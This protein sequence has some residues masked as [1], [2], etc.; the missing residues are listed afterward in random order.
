[1]DP[2]SVRVARRTLAESILSSASGL[3]TVANA[4]IAEVNFRLGIVSEFVEGK[5]PR[6][7]DL[8]ADQLANLRGINFLSGNVDMHPFNLGLSRVGKL[9]SFDSDRAFWPGL[10]QKETLLDYGFSVPKLYTRRFVD[11][12]TDLEPARLSALL[13]ANCTP[14]EIAGVQFRREL[15]LRDL[16]IRG[17]S[18]IVRP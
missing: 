9:K 18:A 13:N 17:A 14:E 15:I 10:P 12:V 5:G 11:F 7:D 3:D 8:P 2:N 6:L 1:M 16:K 4:K